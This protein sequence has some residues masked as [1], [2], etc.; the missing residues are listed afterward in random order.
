MMVS[1]N[2]TIKESTRLV[3][4]DYLRG[5]FIVVIIIDHLSRW[6]SLLGI[7]SGKALLWV[8][9]AEGFVIISGL[10]VGYVRGYKNRALSMRDISKKLIG[11]GLL[12]YL[13]SIIASVAY[14]AV[15]WYVPLTGG[16]PGMPIDKGNWTSLIIDTL[17]LNY[18]YV[19]VHFL[20]Y[21]ALFLVGAPI[22]VWL[23]R[24][25]KAWLVIAISLII[26]AIGWQTHIDAMQWQALFFIPSVAGYYLEPIRSRWLA[27]S[28]KIRKALVVSAW[29]LTAVTITL[30]VISTFYPGGLTGIANVLNDTF[31]AKDTISIWRLCLAFIWFIGF[32]LLFQRFE[33]WIGK[34]LGW[35]LLPIG[36]RSL[37]A[38]IVHGIALIIISSVTVAGSNILVNTLLGITAILIT[39]ILTSLPIVQ[40]IIPR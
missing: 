26:L 12:L 24:K 17:N 28:K 4:L 38:Y 14:T 40:K 2:K 9:A 13:W 36:T 20:T 30:S 8:T 35:L 19:W 7:F 11:R 29:T 31:F 23:L 1:Q 10:L 34:R 37:T 21:Y 6:P 33:K 16:A 3:P 15:I 5:F 39:W 32:M 18:T 27:L 25:S 22:A